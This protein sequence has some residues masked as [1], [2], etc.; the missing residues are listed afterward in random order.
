MSASASTTF[1]SELI[2]D[3]MATDSDNKN[4]DIDF[5]AIVQKC[6]DGVENNCDI[7]DVP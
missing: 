6:I 7:E 1:N 3:N 4:P 2:G 5:R